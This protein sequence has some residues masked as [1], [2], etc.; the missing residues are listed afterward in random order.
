MVQA[1]E[2]L[3]PP[4][5]PNVAVTPEIDEDGWEDDGLTIRQRLFVDALLGPA[6]GCATK[7]AEM[8][9]YRS[10]NRKALR[11][12]AC[13]NLVKPNVQAAISRAYVKLRSSPEW[14]KAGVLDVASSSFANF[15]TLGEN[16]EPKVD[17]N[18]AAEAGA[19]GQIK[20]YRE[21]VMKVGDSEVS[22]IKR[23]IKIHDRTP[24]LALL[25]KFHG[26]LIDR[27]EHSGQ[28]SLYTKTIKGVSQD[29]L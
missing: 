1:T 19:F 21:E 9:G 26:M 2:N 25:M 7:A 13:E 27:T 28:V 15:L 4:K 24:A 6:G 22:V 29:D 12:T 11:V 5:I 23:M 20:E 17:F 3:P 16:G 10:D 8:A 18:K 14:T